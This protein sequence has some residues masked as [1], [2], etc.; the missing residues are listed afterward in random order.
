MLFTGDCAIII[1]KYHL[2]EGSL[3]NKN[4]EITR[5]DDA[6]RRMVMGISASTGIP[7]KGV[8][9]AL[10][11]G[12]ID[13]IINKNSE[14]IPVITNL[15]NVSNSKVISTKNSEFIGEVIGNE[16]PTP[17]TVTDLGNINK[18]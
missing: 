1:R 2:T 12:F 10:D 9:D 16:H 4:K 11:I 17:K 6:L 13:P 15:G 7:V 8:T 3:W 18:K 5:L 14:G